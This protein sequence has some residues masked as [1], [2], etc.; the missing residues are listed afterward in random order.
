M[1]KQKKTEWNLC[2]CV[3]IADFSFRILQAAKCGNT[4]RLKLANPAK[5]CYS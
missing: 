3:R 2:W 5:L 1:Q 4:R